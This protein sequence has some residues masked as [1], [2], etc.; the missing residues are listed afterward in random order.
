MHTGGIMKSNEIDMTSGSLFK[1]IFIFAIPLMLSNLLQVMFNLADV[2]VV[3][4]FVGAIALGAVGSTSILVMMTTGMMLGM[5]GGVNAVVALYV[6]AKDNRNVRK[7]VHTS[8]IICFALGILLL[9]AGLFLTRPMLT[10]IG[11]KDELIDGAAIYLTVY[12]LGSP[13]L[14][15]YNYGN[16]VLSAIGDTK[17]PLIYL[18]IAGVINVVLNLVFVIGFKVGV[19]GVALASIISQYISAFLVIKFLITCRADYGLNIKEIGIDKKIAERVLRIGVPAAVQYTLFAVANLY[20]Q[21]A[22]NSFDHVVVEGNSAAANADNIVYD[23]MAAFYTACTSFIAQNLGARKK[24]R[25]KKAFFVT[26]MYSALIGVVFGALLFI[27]RIQFLHLFTN[28]DQVVYYGGIRLAIMSCSY[29][30]SAFMDNP[31][32]GARGLGKSVIPTI[33]VI[34]GSVVF[35]IIWV[36]TIF[37]SIRTLESLYLVYASA[38]AFTA[39]VGY[40]YFWYEYRKC[41]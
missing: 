16:A 6:G 19:V 40:I 21:S 23:M 7:A 17:R 13:A 9:L 22:V 10:L 4:N 2:A 12:L 41:M 3:G 37:A 38:W 18:A 28:D 33:I 1:K 25:I 35:R 14:A 15:L 32:A 34:M 39:I 36:C 11:T 20:I 8:I 24:D 27:F 30:I 5:S 29:F 31:A 26:Q